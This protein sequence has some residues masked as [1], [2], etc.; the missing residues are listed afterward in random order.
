MKQ[1]EHKGFH[2][3]PMLDT[4]Y[5]N[6]SNHW[7]S[8]FNQRYIAGVDIANGLDS[9]STVVYDKELN[10]IISINVHEFTS[11]S[12]E[13]P[14]Y[15]GEKECTCFHSPKQKKVL[16]GACDLCKNEFY[17]WLET[18]E[19]AFDRIA[20][21]LPD[22]TLDLS[23]LEVRVITKLG[24]EFLINYLKGY[25]DCGDDIVNTFTSNA[26]KKGLKVMIINLDQPKK[27]HPKSEYVS[28]KVSNK[29]KFT[30]YVD[31]FT[32]EILEG[33][34]KITPHLNEFAA[35]TWETENKFRMSIKFFDLIKSIAGLE[36]VQ[37][38]K[39][40]F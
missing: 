32:V 19:N 30:R 1:R 3:D 7:D 25:F 12:T 29:V 2:L 17:K 35:P 33:E 26:K 10:K 15:V 4:K 23:K 16:E 31:Y 27:S 8:T 9:S 5:F 18:Q 38:N 36:N 34:D 28:K 40:F 20:D 11:N 13:K 6:P 14:I 21:T 39:D 37:F 24:G 22:L